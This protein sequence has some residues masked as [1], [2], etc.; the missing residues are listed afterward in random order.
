MGELGKPLT[1][2]PL[3]HVLCI[4]RDPSVPMSGTKPK[5]TTRPFHFSLP[6]DFDRTSNKS[7]LLSKILVSGLF[8]LLG[9]PC[10]S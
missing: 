2:L 8:Y 1:I 4:D 7:F 9:C 6:L 3:L 10:P 5:D